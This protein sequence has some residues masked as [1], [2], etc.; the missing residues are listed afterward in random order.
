M[1]FRQKLE[2]TINKNDSLVCVGLDPEKEKDALFFF[3]KQIIDTTYDLV[4]CYKPNSAFYEAYGLD[5]LKQ[6]KDTIEY[7]QKKY[8]EIP[9]ILD[10]KRG[11]I[12][13]TSKMYAK[14]VF[15]Y[16]DADAVTVSPFYGR[17]SL[18]PF[19]EY[20]NKLIFILVKTSNPDAKMFQDYLKVVQTIKT[21]PFENMG[22]VV[23]ATYPQELKEVREI[24]SSSIILSAGIGIQGAD[25]EKAVKSGIDKEGSGIVF[26]ASRSI[27]YAS[28][29]REATIKLRDEINKYRR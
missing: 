8:P 16:W 21:W 17:D 28:N 27:L 11:D 5:G 1:N 26:N 10:A 24:F 6:L 22:L 3:N 20:K 9:I 12:G 15:D 4:A 18:E 19:F 13:N 23:G 14:A 29:P 7:I 25:I 2:K